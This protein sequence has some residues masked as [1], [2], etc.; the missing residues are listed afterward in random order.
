MLAPCLKQQNQQDMFSCAL[1]AGYCIC[2]VKRFNGSR[3]QALGGI[4]N[5][6]MMCVSPCGMSLSKDDCQPRK[7]QALPFS[8]LLPFKSLWLLLQPN[9]KESQG[10]SPADLLFPTRAG[11][12][13]ACPGPNSCMA[14]LAS[15]WRRCSSCASSSRALH[16]QSTNFSK[17]WYVFPH[18]LYFISLTH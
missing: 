8:A 3:L 14:G 17:S 7:M 15:L 18:G 13:L 11:P 6:V 12:G 16:E 2:R 1:A 9:P 10:P 5:A 4:S